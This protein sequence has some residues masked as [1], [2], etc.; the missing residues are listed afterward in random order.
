MKPPRHGS[1]YFHDPMG[2][3]VE[4]IARRNL[5]HDVEGGFTSEMSLRVSESYRWI[6][7]RNL[8]T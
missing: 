1:V 4:F 8:G 3:I 6:A 2:N 7:S 5:D